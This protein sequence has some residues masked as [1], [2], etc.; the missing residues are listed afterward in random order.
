MCIQHYD[1]V[2]CREPVQILMF[3]FL[4]EI[5]PLAMLQRWKDKTLKAGPAQTKVAINSI[6]F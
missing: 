6:H 5:K 1:I 2:L 4:S 3:S